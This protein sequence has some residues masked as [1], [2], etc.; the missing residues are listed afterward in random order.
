MTEDRADKTFSRKVKEESAKNIPQA[1]HCRLA[2]LAVILFSYGTLTEKDGERRLVI[3]C[4]QEMI[5]RK[6]FTLTEKTFN[7]S[8]GLHK[9][10]HLYHMEIAG[11]EFVSEIL[12]ALKMNSAPI[13]EL[14]N[15][16]RVSAV[17]LKTE[18]CRRAFLRS[19][20]F[21]FGSLSDPQ[22]GY[23]LEFVCQKE[24]QA[25]QIAEILNDFEITAK[26]TVRKKYYVVYLKE[27]SAIVDLLNILGTHV[28]M[29]ELEN[30]RILHEIAG[31]TNRRVNCE[32]ANLLKS[33]N[34][35]N[36][37]ID[38][39][40]YIEKTVGLKTLPKPLYEIAVVRLEHDDATL[41]E[42]GEFLDPHVGKSGVNHRLRKIS[43]IAESLRGKN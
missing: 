15:M 22:K 11:E 4:E 13:G 36:S 1:R 5:A 33:V 35:A 26:I 28:A 24:E 43:E 29:M 9:N 38:D 10:E 31:D 3:S 20:F 2:E 19:C 41:K 40:K 12:S 30:F 14:K 37:Q 6:C 16:G 39:I 7:I 42:L 34:A 18:C 17:L 8:V 21:C 32:T 27:G 25:N 23:H